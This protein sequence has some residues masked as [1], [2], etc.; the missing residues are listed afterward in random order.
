MYKLYLAKVN[1]YS[2]YE[3]KEKSTHYIFAATSFAG[4]AEKLVEDWGE[5]SIVTMTISPIGDDEDANGITISESMYNALLH[6][7]PEDVY[8][9]P[10]EWK[11]KYEKEKNNHVS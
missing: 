7:M 3:D 1:W 8:C 9:L 6:D 2:E 11:R 5:D 10:S 4:A